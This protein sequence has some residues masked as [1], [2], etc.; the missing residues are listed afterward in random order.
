MDQTRD[1]GI[2]LSGRDL[3]EVKAEANVTDAIDIGADFRE[4]DHSF[5]GAACGLARVSR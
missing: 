2:S 5:L 1:H 3:G 4:L